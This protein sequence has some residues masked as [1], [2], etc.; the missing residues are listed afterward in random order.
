MNKFTEL[1]AKDKMRIIELETK[2]NSKIVNDYEF[3]EK[4]KELVNEGFSKN[5]AEIFN[6]F[7]NKSDEVAELFVEKYFL[8]LTKDF[9]YVEEA[10]LAFDKNKQVLHET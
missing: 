2:I 9:A 6:L 5:R 7:S 8:E 1:R 4:V 3:I 10:F